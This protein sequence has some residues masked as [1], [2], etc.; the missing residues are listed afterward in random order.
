MLFIL[1][2]MFNRSWANLMIPGFKFLIIIVIVSALYGTIRF[3]NS[4][5][6]LVFIWC[7]MMACFLGI[8]IVL[9]PP[10]FASLQ[11]LSVSVIGKREDGNFR[12]GVS[13]GKSS[14]SL[15]HRLVRR[16]L[17]S[18]TPLTCR[19]GAFYT[20]DRNTGLTCLNLVFQM[21]AYFLVAG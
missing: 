21:T 16:V 3:S 18:C 14:R 19:A 15:E 6:F 12:N 2:D 10:M 11:E 4:V 7:P 8:V 20:F 5:E 9:I 17:E 1:N 13:S